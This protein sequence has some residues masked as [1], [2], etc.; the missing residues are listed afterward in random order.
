MRLHNTLSAAVLFMRTAATAVA[1]APAE[2]DTLRNRQLQQVEVISTRATDSTPVAFTNLSK[3][4]IEKTNFGQDLPYLLQFTPSVVTTSDAGGG[5]GYTTLRVRGTDATRINVT[6][7]G[8]PVNDAESHSVFWVNMPDLASSLKDAQLQRGVGTS[9]N[10]AGAFGANLNLRTTDYSSRPYAEL[11]GSYGSF[12]THK[13]TFKVGTGLLKGHWDFNARLSNIGT[14]GFIDRAAVDL[15]SYYLQGGFYTTDTRVRLVVFGGKE[16]TYHA[17]NYAS[18]EEMEEHNSRRY[19]SCGYMYTDEYGY[20]HFYDDQ[21][22]NYIQTN[23]QLLLDHRLSKQFNLNVGL[24]YTRGDGYYQEY[25]TNRKLA[26]Y[27]LTPYTLDGTTVKKSDLVRRKSMANNF[28]GGVFAVNYQTKRLHATLG[29][30]FN[31]YD[32]DHFGQV[33]WVKNYIGTDADPNNEYY[34]NTGT[35]NDGNVY[36]RADYEPLRGLTGYADLQYRHI[37]YQIDGT[38]DKWYGDAPQRFDIDDKFDFF[39]PKVGV[40]WQHRQHRAYASFSVAHKEPTRNNYTD[41]YID[42]HPT[43]E[44]LFDYEVGYTFT[45]KWFRAGINL[46]YMDYKDQLVLT[47]ELNEIGEAVAANIP[48]SYRTGVE[49]TA[50]VDLPCGFSWDA[51]ATLSRNRTR[52]FVETLYGYDSEWNELDPIQIQHGS[53]HLAFSPDVIFNNRFAYRFKGFETAL[54]SQYVGKQYMS[55]ADIEAHRLDA[56]FV[57]NLHLSYTF[58]PKALKSLTVG[59]SIYNL[60]NQMYENNGWA[61]SDYTDTPDHRNNYTGYAA[62]AGT[63][64]MGHVQFRF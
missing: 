26:E 36:L 15:Y 24:H 21:T 37:R 34:R 61:S 30:G 7:N 39:N 35:K 53:T 10:G 44:R 48:K 52:D 19:N 42:R 3:E 22:D 41:G 25:K 23:Y 14:D 40:N 55:N 58:K 32:G 51:N 20:E 45:H 54:Q 50:G 18:H 46:F 43:S 62:Q 59:C 49:L 28:G 63:H 29:G 9:T 13:E 11:N 31:R 56:Y 33:M 57:S 8:I 16:K 60:F 4:Q 47:G 2:P 6:I 27:G 17:W 12:N 38:N 1:S 64:V 5:I